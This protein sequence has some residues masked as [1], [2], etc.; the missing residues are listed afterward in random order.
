MVLYDMYIL[1]YCTSRGR[2]G[3]RRLILGVNGVPVNFMV[4]FGGF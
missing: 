4:G 1:L 2:S 3:G